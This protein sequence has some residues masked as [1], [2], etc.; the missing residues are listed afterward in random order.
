MSGKKV[1]FIDVGEG[2]C[3]LLQPQGKWSLNGTDIYVDTGNGNKDIA[4]VS[5]SK[6]N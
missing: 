5:H 4:K 3:I 1:K 2:D 6:K